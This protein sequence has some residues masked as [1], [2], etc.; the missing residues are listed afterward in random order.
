MLK[1]VGESVDYVRKGKVEVYHT[2]LNLLEIAWKLSKT[3]TSQT[4]L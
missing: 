4:L 2:E 3:A 1:T